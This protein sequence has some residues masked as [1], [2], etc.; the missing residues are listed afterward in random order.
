MSAATSGPLKVTYNEETTELGKS[1]GVVFIG[2][3]FSMIF[4]GINSYQLYIYFST[5]LKERSLHRWMIG[6]LG[7]LDS[8]SVGL[9][10][11]VV[12]FYMVS[13]FPF[14]LPAV[15]NATGTFCADNIIAI[16]TIFVVQLAYAQRV[17]KY[18]AILAG[19]LSV[20]ALVAAALGLVMSI[21]LLT[22]PDFNDLDEA[23]HMGVIGSCQA[24]TFVVSV[25]TLIAILLSE[26]P[27]SPS[28]SNLAKVYDR[29]ISVL[30]ETGAAAAAVQGAY[31]IIFFSSP[32]NRFWIPFQFISRRL[33]FLSLLTLYINDGVRERRCIT[34]PATQ[35]GFAT[36]DF[37]TTVDTRAPSGK[38]GAF[39]SYLSG[40]TH[41]DNTFA[42]KGTP[43]FNI[44]VTREVLEDSDTFS[45]K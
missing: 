16:I 18:N 12:H 26:N 2:Y 39:A 7:M 34:S 30:F 40:D 42:T 20:L 25:I 13:Q 6:L 28:K 10:T 37:T 3:V 43:V 11:Q 21:R 27:V 23:S 31:L 41:S 24:I 38:Q 17:Q 15:Q 8:T 44:S 45:P 35:L 29:M 22:K 14:A 1:V 36:S 9:M 32:T 5:V 4:Y 33:F 19:V